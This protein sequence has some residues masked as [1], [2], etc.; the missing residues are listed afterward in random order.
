MEKVIIQFKMDAYDLDGNVVMQEFEHGVPL[1]YFD[2]KVQKM[3]RLTTE[4]VAKWIIKQAYKTKT[5]EIL[6][7]SRK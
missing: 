2:D 4:Q 6:S 5:V 7:M 3:N 1:Q